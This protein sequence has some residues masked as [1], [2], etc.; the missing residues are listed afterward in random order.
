MDR[1][2]LEGRGETMWEDHPDT[3]TSVSNLVSVLKYQGKYG[4]AEKMNQ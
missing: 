4:V 2:P 1:R 3:L